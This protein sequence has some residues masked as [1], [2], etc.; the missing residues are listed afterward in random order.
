MANNIRLVKFHE[1][2]ED[3]AQ[4]E[5]ELI[6]IARNDVHIANFTGFRSI[7]FYKN[8][9]IDK[10]IVEISQSTLIQEIIHQAENSYN[11][12]K[13]HSFRDIFIT[14]ST[15]A[16]KSVM[17]QIPA[18]YLAKHYQKLT[19]IIEPVKALMQDQKE[20]LIK[21]G[22]TRVETFNSDLISSS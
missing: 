15:G 10:E 21:N 14:A 3:D 22:Y 9:D 12:E 18:I 19:I 8:P 5:Q 1:Y 17:F 2:L 16:G 7:K 11:T 13:G 20:K 4:M 6:D